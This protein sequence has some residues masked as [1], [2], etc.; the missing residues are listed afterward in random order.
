V[1]VLERDR[2]DGQAGE[3]EVADILAAA[4]KC[5][6]RPTPLRSYYDFEFD[7]NGRTVGICE[8][9]T[10]RFESFKYADTYLPLEKWYRLLDISRSLE[11][12]GIFVA[13]FTDE[14]RWIEVGQI[15]ARRHEVCGRTDRPDMPH[16]WSTKILVPVADMARLAK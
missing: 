4:W 1:N 2:A 6:V 13:N 7:R 10:R 9:K 8:V 3:A 11:V 15:D 16:D 5:Q 12:V 14:I